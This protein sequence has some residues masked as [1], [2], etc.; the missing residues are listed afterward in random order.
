[1]NALRRNSGAMR[2]A[3]R[4]STDSDTSARASSSRRLLRRPRRR[5]VSVDH[6]FHGFQ[7][8]AGED[9]GLGRR[10]QTPRACPA[11]GLKPASTLD[12]ARG[13]CHRAGQSR[14]GHK[15]SLLPLI[16]KPTA[17]KSE[18]TVSSPSH[19]QRGGAGIGV[20]IA[21]DQGIDF[22]G[23]RARRRDAR[24]VQTR[25]TTRFWKRYCGC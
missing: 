25:K 6:V 18:H 2:S 4:R 14:A 10:E 21:G 17:R 16:D 19:A 3:R 9:G 5:S 7:L 13:G 11:H 24:Q 1:L 22:D 23:Q 15:S 12:A 8:Q 20:G